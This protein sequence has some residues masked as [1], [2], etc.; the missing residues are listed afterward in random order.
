MTI[1]ISEEDYNLFKDHN[2]IKFVTLISRTHEDNVEKLRHFDIL[3][4]NPLPEKKDEY[5]Y[6][7]DKLGTCYGKDVNYHVV[8]YN[9]C[10]DD[11][12]GEDEWKR[13][14]IIQWFR[15]HQKTYNPKY[16]SLSIESIDSLINWFKSLRSKPHWKPTKEQIEYLSK[17]IL[18]LGEEGD[19]KTAAVLNELRK[20]LKKMMEE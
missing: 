17:A 13:E 18:T 10:I 11:I 16:D 20:D 5:R 19:A 12:L 2:G 14:G 4:L 9:K 1:E 15:K 7:T 8:G 3:A 6:I